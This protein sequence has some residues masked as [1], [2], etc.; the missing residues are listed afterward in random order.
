MRKLVSSER[1]DEKIERQEKI[2]QEREGER[3]V[4]EGRNSEK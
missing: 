4:R 1:H 3:G 2:E